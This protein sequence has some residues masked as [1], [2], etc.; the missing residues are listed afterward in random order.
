M[1]AETAAFLLIGAAAGGFVNGL[2]GFGTALFALGWWLHVMPPVQ[3][4]AVV[5]AL[6]VASGL[7]G[8]VRVRHAI[9]PR[10]LALFL[11]PA[12]AGIPLGLVLLKRVDAEIL[13]IVVGGFLLLY[14]VFFVARRDLPRLEPPAWADGVV[15]AVGGVLGALAGRPRRAPSC[16]PSTS[17]CWAC[18]PCFWRS[19]AATMPTRCS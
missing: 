11:V 10:R 4:V 16:S 8:V 9:R 3:A 18:P 5:L 2:A 19:P 17:W 1:T 14:A 7:Q 15:G 13:K 6:S 12:L